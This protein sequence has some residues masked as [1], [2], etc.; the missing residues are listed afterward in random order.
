NKI[1][2]QAKYTTPQD[3]STETTIIYYAID[4]PMQIK[5]IPA[6]KIF[7]YLSL[8]P[9]FRFSIKSLKKW[10]DLGYAGRRGPESE[11]TLSG[12]PLLDISGAISLGKNV[13][14][15]SLII[16]PEITFL[17]GITKYKN[18]SAFGEWMN[19]TLKLSIGILY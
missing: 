15:N 19:Y 6:Q 5:F 4:F 18:S 7:P 1:L 3:Y 10:K 17:K 16:I 2:Q 13:S 11:S 9:S 8:G 14:F 12:I